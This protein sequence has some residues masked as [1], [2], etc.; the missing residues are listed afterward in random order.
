[1]VES[2]TK[3]HVRHLYKTI[4]FLLALSLLQFFVPVLNV[5]MELRCCEEQRNLPAKSMQCCAA[6]FPTRMVC[7]IDMPEHALDDSAPAQAT[8]AKPSH[9][10]SDL[11]VSSKLFENGPGF[12]LTLTTNEVFSS[13][14]L[15]LANNQRYKLFATFLI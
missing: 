9:V 10:P 7:C 12:A 2:R 3:S 14:S 8:L 11:A 15:Y 6:E 13:L 4:S 5:A 1:M